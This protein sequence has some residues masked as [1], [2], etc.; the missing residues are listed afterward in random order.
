MG[1]PRD[2][3]LLLV[4]ALKRGIADVKAIRKALDRQVSRP[5]PLLEALHLPDAESL[6]LRGD[7]SLPDP[8]ADRKILDALCSMLLEGEYLTHAEWEKFAAS[9]VRPTQRMGYPP[10]PVPQEFDGFT[11]QW[12]LARRE[13]GVVYRA[14]DKDGRDVAIKVFRKD[15]SVAPEL[16]RV[17]GLAYAVA[18]FE[19]G[20]T[21]EHRKL[22]ARR[23]VE[24]LAQAADQLRERSHGAITPA[25]ILV[26]KDDTV[27]LLGLGY[28][29]AAPLSGRAQA[30][31]GSGDAH[32]LGAI[33][34]ESIVGSP[35][36][37]ET[38]PA[39]RSRETDP[40]LDRVVSAALSGGYASP[41]ELADDLRRYLRG[42]P[43]TARKAPAPAAA[44]KRLP[45]GWIAAAAVPVV[46]G[47]VYFATRGG[48]APAP[49][50]A[51][52]VVQAPEKPAVAPAPEKPKE[53]V[54]PAPVRPAVAS[55]PL[56]KEDEDSLYAGTLKAL[57]EGDHDRIIELSNEAVA[58]G[59][60]KD[61]PLYH[62]ANAFT[63]RGELDK[64]L[65][66]VSR[67][68]EAS[69]DNR[70]TLE[71]RAHVYAFRGEATKALAD[72]K[73][74]FGGKPAELN[75]QVVR[76]SKEVDADPKDARSR[77]L[78]GV[79]YYLKEHFDS[80]SRD[81]TS[82]IELGQRRALAWRARAELGLKDH[83]HALLDAKA[84]LTEFPSDFATSEVKALLVEIQK[85]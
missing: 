74:L 53:T 10:L 2:D 78:R 42:E 56:T 75:R 23:T 13:R 80:A 5:I 72:L 12:E 40:A 77:L 20:E 59:S 85:K 21:L 83:E 16:P 66:Y 45:W 48:D 29:K 47:V 8:L 38:S 15:V 4:R 70:D 61:W 9:L 18:S 33:L 28:A 55:A 25:R 34:Y 39:A 11:V 36:A 27:A 64:A 6:T 32:A 76:L 22:S 44:R 58:R 17:E 37:G 3:L 71:T 60:K 43:V 41:G 26:R 81:F 62:L 49:K 69:P 67:A 35:P 84:Y 54:N 30:Y 7:V 65:E 63:A 68:L 51:P 24:A 14:K 82:A 50:P 79:F 52:P 46:A 31:S 19:E 73:Q 57:G 1:V